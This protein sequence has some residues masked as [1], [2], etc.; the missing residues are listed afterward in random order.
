MSDTSCRASVVIAAH[1]EEHVLGRCLQALTAGGQSTDLEIVVAANGCS[2]HTAA[3]AR[4]FPGVIVAELPTAGK[5]AAL[6]AAE[7]LVTSFPRIYLDADICLSADQCRSLCQAVDS[8]VNEAHGQQPQ[9]LVAFPT[10]RINLRGRPLPVRAY[11]VIN[12]RLP[13][14]TTGVFGRG[15]VC[16]SEAG[17]GRFDVFPEVLADDLFL[18]SVFTTAEK[19]QISEVEVVV[20]AP[21]STRSLLRRLE[22]VRR[23]NR[24]LRRDFVGSPTTSVR[25]VRTLSWLTDVALRRPWLLPAAGIYVVL[26]AVAEVRSRNALSEAA[27]GRDDSTRSPVAAASRP[28][29]GPAYRPEV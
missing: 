10:R 16:L 28:P 27:W 7:K 21:R 12:Q 4:S 1:N 9:A 3:V 23:A 5:A 6:N 17:R 24:R 8:S 26:T 13:A 22:R 15:V 25:P 11:F 19:H 18:D 20:Q 29:T 2:D 14:F